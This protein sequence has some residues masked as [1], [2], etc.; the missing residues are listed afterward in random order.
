M[1]RFENTTKRFGHQA[2]LT[3]VSFTCDPGTVTGFLGPNGAGK[4]TA[5][6]ILAGITRATS[7]TALVDGRRYRDLPVPGRVVG[8]V[9]DAAAQ[10]P[11]R[12]GREALRLAASMSDLPASR[13]EELLERVGLGNAARRRV[14]TYS[15]GMRQRLGIAQA[16]LGDPYV[17]ILDEPANGLDP[18]GIRWMR[19][20]LRVFAAGGGTV[21][22]SSHLLSEVEATVDRL[23]VISAGRVVAQGELTALLGGAGVVVNG[24]DL[25][26]L[27]IA[28]SGAGLAVSA[29]SGGL[30]VEADTETVG[31]VASAAGQVLTELRTGGGT[32]L[33]DL[34]FDLTSGRRGP[35]GPPGTGP[36]GTRLVAA[37][38]KAARDKEVLA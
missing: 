19:E 31:R 23:V 7:G 18:E 20:T 14:G 26:G 36:A 27:R 13:A 33:E 28:L 6:R 22:L 1:I 25:V 15:L 38:D 37:R 2:A 29:A 4:S 35:T 9:L 16:M 24:P 30:R 11:G 32:G 10:H 12:T 21:L 5:L 8:T 3:E 34:F 17:L